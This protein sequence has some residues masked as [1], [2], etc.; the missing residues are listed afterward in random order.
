MKPSILFLAN[1]F[2][3]IIFSSAVF[4]GDIYAEYKMT[5]MTNKPVISKMYSKNGDLRTDVTMDIGGSLMQ[6]TTLMLK[7]KPNVTLVFNSMNKTYTETKS[8]ANAIIKNFDIKVLG[9]EKVGNYNCTHVRMSANGKSWDMWYSKD[10]PAVNFPLTS[11]DAASSQKML[12]QLKSKGIT[13]MPVKVAF[14]KPNST[15]AAVTM[16]LTKFEQKTLNAALF[17]I[18]AGYTKNSVSFDAEKMKSMTPQQ[19]KEMIMKMMKEQQL[20]Q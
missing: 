2:F 8:S 10:L 19:K 4:A 20:K 5:G 12:A 16:L 11:S 15:T 9:N 17:T 14:L 1:L 13:G 18:P 3:L 6:T 7:S